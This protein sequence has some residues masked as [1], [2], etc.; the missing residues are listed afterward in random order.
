[1]DSL[2][3][4]LRAKYNPEG[5]LLRQ[6]Q[7]RMIDLLDEI[8]RICKK[9]QIHYWLSSGTLLGAVRH[10][11]FIPWDDDL[12]IE[13][14]EDDYKR[15]LQVMPQELPDHLALQSH[16]TD[17]NYIYPYA[18]LRDR[19][20]YLEEFCIYDRYFKEKGIF[21]DIFPM[22]KIPKWVAWISGHM[23]GQIYNQFN[24]PKLDD[25]TRLRRAKRIWN[26]NHQIGFPILRLV[27]KFF[28]MSK[29]RHTF[30]T[31]YLGPR[32][33]KDIL[34]LTEMDFECKR[35][36]VPHDAD[37]MLKRL[38]GDYMKLPDL[39]NLKPH[40]SKLKIYK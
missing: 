15:L 17:P 18:K 5:S 33:K 8:D 11:G 21:I 10:Q 19:N 12:D 3:Q 6:E 9:H 37:A 40:C 2:T 16:E 26:F 24:N 13:M 38:Y 27:S 1:M 39:S 30:G 31:G 7:L 32:V 29:Y 14:F 34:P 4:E 23:H 28:W 22:I 35:Y 25:T 36:P 20:S